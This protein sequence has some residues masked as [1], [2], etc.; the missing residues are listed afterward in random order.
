MVEADDLDSTLVTTLFMLSCGA[1][2]ILLV[3]CYCCAACP[4]EEAPR[5]G[6]VTDLP[7]V[8]QK[9]HAASRPA[10]PPHPPPCHATLRTLT[11]VPSCGCSCQLYYGK[12]LYSQ[13]FLADLWMALRNKHVFFSVLLA[14]PLHPF[15]KLERLMVLI[16]TLLFAY[17][18]ASLAAQVFEEVLKLLPDETVAAWYQIS[19]LT[20]SI[21]VPEGSGEQS[22]GAALDVS[23]LGNQVPPL[24][25]GDLAMI[26]IAMIV[27]AFY[28]TFV[29]FVGQCP[30]LAKSD[31]T[32][33]PRLH[34]CLEHSQR[35]I[36]LM[37]VGS[38]AFVASG[39]I[40]SVVT[41][42]IT[43]GTTTNS[44]MATRT[45]A[46]SRASSWLGT[47]MV[48]LMLLTWLKR[49]KERKTNFGKL[50][51]THKWTPADQLPRWPPDACLLWGWCLPQDHHLKRAP[52]APSDS[53]AGAS[54]GRSTSSAIVTQT[55]LPTQKL[56]G[57]EDR[58]KMSVAA[59]AQVD[60][61]AQ[62]RESSHANLNALETAAVSAAEQEMEEEEMEAV[63]E[64]PA[65]ACAAAAGGTA[66]PGAAPSKK[67][68]RKKKN[69][70]SV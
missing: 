45:W 21:E 54:Q 40:I 24:G 56:P 48:V 43:A 14:H 49:R 37:L 4:P 66:P 52:V 28:D 20:L 57:P 53:D 11:L 51:A 60:K 18:I 61:A 46:I 31:E 69:V 10:T 34:A 39:P 35:V 44:E 64:A 2:V 55:E 47:S 5:P 29:R 7:E 30:C 12:A 3:L 68:R 62:S 33:R 50:G 16:A 41:E 17:G 25:V 15:S 9:V 22:S 59:Q 63:E 8:V 58:R 70:V 26:V 32:K 67:R 27:Q 65:A 38:A 13:S 36:G 6:P 1:L 19:N 23:G 42:D